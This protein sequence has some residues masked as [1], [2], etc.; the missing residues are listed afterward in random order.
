MTATPAPR[1]RPTQARSIATREKLIQTALDVIYE[2]GYHR[3]STTKFADR[4]GVSRGA[5]LHHF[6]T[7]SDIMVAA[8]EKLLAD[9]TQEIRD[10]AEAVARGEME[11]VGFVEFLWTLFSGRFFYLSVEFINETRIDRDLRARMIPVVRHFHEALNQIWCAFSKPDNGR[12]HEAQVMLNLTVCL[13]RGMGIQTI[14]KDDPA[15]F[16]SLLDAWK[17]ILPQLVDGSG[18]DLDWPARAGGERC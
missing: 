5:L 4:A 12:P 17:V 18:H 9:G 16:R 6:P 14:L 8:M 13:V 15:Y 2:E 7:R 11:L 3:A 10:T 1:A